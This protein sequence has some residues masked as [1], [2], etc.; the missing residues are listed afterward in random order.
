MITFGFVSRMR[1]AVAAQLAASLLIAIVCGQPA[2]GAAAPLEWQAPASIRE[3]AE[4]AAAA[5]VGAGEE[6]EVEAAAIDERLRLPACSQP[7]DARAE[8]AL[9]NGRGTITVRCDGVRPWKLYVPVS[10]S[11]LVPVVVATHALAPAAVIGADDVAVE[12]RRSSALPYQYLSR[13][14]DAVGFTTRRSVPAGSVLAPAALEQRRLVARGSLVTL[15]ASAR[16]IEVSG[17][18]VAVEDA[19]L[20]QRIRVRTPAG[21]VVEGIV[22]GPR[23][24]RVGR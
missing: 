14:D 10:V 4:I 2:T 16:G 1:R 3:V 20:R 17:R 11:A 24:V 9:H 12:K 21:R 15:V 7:L 18:G 19:G 22:E 23:H 13:T 5:Q 6:I 8:R